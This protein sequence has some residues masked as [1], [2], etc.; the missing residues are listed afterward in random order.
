MGITK[1]TKTTKVT[2]SLAQGHLQ[3]CQSIGHTSFRLNLPL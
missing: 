1:V 3:S 2:F